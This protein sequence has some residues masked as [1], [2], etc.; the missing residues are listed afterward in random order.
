MTLHIHY[1]YRCQSCEAFYIPYGPD[2]ACPRCGHHDVGNWIDFVPRAAR[3]I[4]YNLARYG[5]YMPPAWFVGSLGDHILH[6]LFGLFERFRT[7][8]NIRDFP[9]FAAIHLA[10]MNWGDQDYLRAHIAALAVEIQP[11]L[12][13]HSGDDM[14]NH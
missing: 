6:I 8:A 11:L 7:E 1:N 5:S 4:D 12:A 14:G 3:S 9:E 13:P 2:V 10:A